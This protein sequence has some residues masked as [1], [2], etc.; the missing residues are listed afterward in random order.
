MG[1]MRIIEKRDNEMVNQIA[2]LLEKAFPP[3]F[4][5]KVAYFIGEEE[6]TERIMLVFE[7]TS[8]TLGSVYK[9][10]MRMDTAYAADDVESDFVGKILADFMLLG[11]T[12]LTNTIM[13]S[14]AAKQEDAEAI[15]IHPF[16]KSRL[17]N[18]NLN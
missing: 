14:R 12:L 7:I 13:A 17:N 3:I 9:K 16:S 18:V 5:Y 11:T 8:K 6:D 4:S 15:L 2:D 10:S 1:K